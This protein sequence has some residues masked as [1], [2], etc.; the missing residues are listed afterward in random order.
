MIDTDDN[1][2]RCLISGFFFGRNYFFLFCLCLLMNSCIFLLFFFQQF[3]FF[4]NFL[5]EIPIPWKVT[6]R[7]QILFIP[8]ESENFFSSFN[9]PKSSILIFLLQISE[10]RYICFSKSWYGTIFNHACFV[11]V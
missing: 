2:L 3:L 6:W 1:L 11:E 10:E 7:L 5:Q 4:Y 9:R 8:V